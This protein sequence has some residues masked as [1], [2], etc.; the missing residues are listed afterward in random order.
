MKLKKLAIKYVIQ[1]YHRPPEFPSS[2]HMQDHNKNNPQKYK[3]K[4]SPGVNRLRTV[5]TLQQP[6]LTSFEGTTLLSQDSFLTF[7]KRNILKIEQEIH[8]A[9]KN[10]HNWSPYCGSGQFKPNRAKIL[11]NRFINCYK[12]EKISI[13]HSE[14]NL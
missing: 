12:N 10:N 1:K 14:T 2:P 5:C 13:T 8:V 7:S 4:K 9:T 6:G 3:T 11:E